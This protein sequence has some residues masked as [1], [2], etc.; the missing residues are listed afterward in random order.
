MKAIIAICVDIPEFQENRILQKDWSKN[1]PGAGWLPVFAEL[2]EK[3]GCSVVTGDVALTKVQ[4]G[5]RKARDILVIQELNAFHGRR[6][7]KLGARPFILTGYESPIFAYRFYDQLSEIAPVFPYRILFAGAF[8]TFKTSSGVNQQAHF[9][10]YHAEDIKSPVP[11]SERDFLVMMAA[12]KYWQEPFSIPLWSNPKRYL[13]W[14]RD[15]WFKY[16]SPARSLAIKNQ[17]HDKRLEAVEYFGLLKLLSLYGPGWQDLSRLPAGWRRRLETIVQ[18]MHPQPCDNKIKTIAGYK[19]AVCF[20]NVSYPGYITEKIIDCFV[21]GV[22]P[23]YLGAPDV[24]DFIPKESFIDMREFA[25]WDQ[26]NLYLNG[27]TEDTACKMISAGREFLNSS[28]GE[29]YSFNGFAKLILDFLKQW[30]KLN[31]DQRR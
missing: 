15:Q 17:L 23:I 25:S 30:R 14:L 1:F 18:K 3:E 13:G 22:I 4:E 6:L 28:R 8:Q 27:I 11:W 24:E 9:P 20:E 29:L 10:N 26:L 19:F 5:C 2:A 21:A 12:N 16:T 31:A 7:I